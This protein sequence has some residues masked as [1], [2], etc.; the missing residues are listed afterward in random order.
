MYV[1]LWRSG[2]LDGWDWFWVASAVVMDIGHWGASFTQ[3][4][5][6]RGYP[7]TTQD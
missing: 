2:G 6:A 7:S 5:Q 4:R 3:G 1:I